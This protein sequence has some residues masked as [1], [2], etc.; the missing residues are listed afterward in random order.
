MLVPVRLLAGILRSKVANPEILFIGIDG[1]SGAGKSYLAQCLAG[2]LRLLGE[3]AHVISV[4][5]FI[6]PLD[7]RREGGVVSS[8]IG[9]DLD[10]RTLRTV[11][12]SIKQTGKA[13]W[14]P[15][16]WQ[17]NLFAQSREIDA[18][19]FLIVEGVYALRPELAHIYDFSFWATGDR[20]GR[21]ER[22]VQRDGEGSRVS[23]MRWWLPDEDVYLAKSI[24]S[25][26][27]ANIVFTIPPNDKGVTEDS[28]DLLRIA[29]G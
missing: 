20:S 18:K 25:T 24:D 12:T 4:D 5:E 17:T 9:H 13:S 1:G 3:E 27:R 14:C 11:L 8:E 23:L 22:A 6:R 16:D 10:W 19:G 29:F 26:H 15:Y 7:D 21:I 28:V 2:R